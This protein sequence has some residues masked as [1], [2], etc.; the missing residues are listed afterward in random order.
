M[1]G[2]ALKKE[3][4]WIQSVIVGGPLLAVDLNQVDSNGSNELHV[5][6]FGRFIYKKDDGIMM[7][8]VEVLVKFGER[9]DELRY[10]AV[11]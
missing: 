10:R 4:G 1:G 2:R 11:R 9:L 8:I 3:G 7:L 6:P 5:L